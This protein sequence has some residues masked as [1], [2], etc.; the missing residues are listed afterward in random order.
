MKNKN[1]FLIS[2]AVMAAA[3]VVLAMAGFA[4][5]GRV[6]GIGAD[7]KGLH[8]YAPA[9]EEKNGDDGSDAAGQNEELPGEFDRM[10]IQAEYAD[11][12]IERTDGDVYSLSYHL[13]GYSELL[14]EVK[15]GKLLLTIQQKGSARFGQVRWFWFGFWP[16]DDMNAPESAGAFANQD[17]PGL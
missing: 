16:Q 6:Y 5:G 15:D 13:P 12:R 10:Q 17:A 7:W 2:C 3:G 14:K 8:V 9:L 1:K 4:A 11:I